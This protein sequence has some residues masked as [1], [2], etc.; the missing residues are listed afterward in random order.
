[1]KIK[2]FRGNDLNKLEDL[3]NLFI[4][5]VKVNSIEIASHSKDFI[6]LITYYDIL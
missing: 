1:M 4:D 2:I 6:V 3:I 5:K